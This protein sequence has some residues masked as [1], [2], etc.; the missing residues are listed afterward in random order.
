MD[1]G[2]IDHGIISALSLLNVIDTMYCKHNPERKHIDVSEEG[3]AWSQHH[4]DNDV[5]PAC[6]AVF[7]HNLKDIPQL[8]RNSAPLAF[9]LRLSD[10]LQDWG[11]PS[12]DNDDGVSDDKFKIQVKGKEIVFAVA[13]NGRREKIKSQI[14]S[15]LIAPDI[16]ITGF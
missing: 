8:D 6:T 1:S 16:T 11:R 14:E 10:T 3:S 12:A 4:F 5:V 9:L 15:H 13:D 7:I 2:K